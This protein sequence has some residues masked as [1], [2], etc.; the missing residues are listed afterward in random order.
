[1]EQEPH[2]ASQQVATRCHR[3]VVSVAW[4][5]GQRATQIASALLRVAWPRHPRHPRH[6]RSPRRP[7]FVVGSC[8]GTWRTTSMKSDVHSAAVHGL[9]PR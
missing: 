4:I 5:V 7:S 1:M 2:R 9:W 3:P 6:S 8:G